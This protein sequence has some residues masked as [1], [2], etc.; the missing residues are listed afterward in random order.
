ML[1]KVPVVGNVTMDSSDSAELAASTVG[2]SGLSPA[3][4]QSPVD[5]P[6]AESELTVTMDAVSAESGGAPLQRKPVDMSA[7]AVADASQNDATLQDSSVTRAKSRDVMDFEHL[8]MKLDQLRGPAVKKDV[9]P[10][11]TTSTAVPKAK[12]DVESE[13]KDASDG[14]APASSVVGS[15][16]TGAAPPT[17]GNRPAANQ[18]ISRLTSTEGSQPGV[19]ASQQL[20]GASAVDTVSPSAPPVTVAVPQAVTAANNVP[21]SKPSPVSAVLPSAT[22]AQIPTAAVAPVAQKPV[23]NM[24]T[25]EQNLAAVLK[26]A[27][28]VG[29]VSVAQPVAQS[30]PSAVSTGLAPPVQTQPQAVT[31]VG[32]VQQRVA[33]PVVMPTHHPTAQPSGM[34]PQSVGQTVPVP[35]QLGVQAQIL[36]QQGQ[37][38]LPNQSVLGQFAPAV[39]HTPGLLPNAGSSATSVMMDGSAAVASTPNSP[40]SC[41]PPSVPS[42]APGDLSAI[43]AMYQQQQLQQQLFYQQLQQAL[44]ARAAAPWSLFGTVLPGGNPLLAAQLA[45]AVQMLM[46]MTPASADSLPGQVSQADLLMYA[47]QLQAQSVLANPFACPESVVQADQAVMGSVVQPAG[48]VTYSGTLSAPPTVRM[49]A[50]GSVLEH[51]GASQLSQRRRAERPDLASL[52][53]ALTKFLGPCKPT[54]QISVAGGQLHSPA[55]HI[56]AANGGHAT[57]SPLSH[58]HIHQHPLGTSNTPAVSSPVLSPVVS[59]DQHLAQTFGV[60]VPEQSLPSSSVGVSAKPELMSTA[61][62]VAAVAVNT[63]LPLTSELEKPDEK[64]VSVNCTNK[65]LPG[66]DKETS[67]SATKRKLQFTVTAVKNDPL[68]ERPDSK[69]ATEVSVTSVTDEKVSVRA[70]SES[71]DAGASSTA[72]AADVASASGSDANSASKAPIKKGRF[73]ILDVKEKVTDVKEN[74]AAPTAAPPTAKSEITSYADAAKSGTCTS[75]AESSASN[76]ASNKPASV[77]AIH[78]SSSQSCVPPA[79]SATTS[80]ASVS[81]LIQP[82]IFFCIFSSSCWRVV[83]SLEHCICIF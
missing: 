58:Q 73:R 68:K 74:P 60:G 67:A 82:L 15:L 24:S 48:N 33:S 55:S 46:A 38:I 30:L 2:K 75:V 4:F 43:T 9:P 53:Q 42:A 37:Q 76:A 1:Q 19:A 77:V 80:T 69:E 16:V 3:V 51:P 54:P 18:Q 70:A 20:A 31:P 79:V 32:L 36:T 35:Q 12:P 5:T 41:Q 40:K 59:L 72:K 63:A 81:Q 8:K 34:V 11:A 29:Q 50:A 25:L 83:Q 21:L 47:Q 26:P 71:C 57:S 28:T 6:V 7:L 52:E 66:I 22:A 23:S 64:P 13:S 62:D 10:A 44:V 17:S 49:Q 14:S 61:V 39:V 45:Y 78:T 65:D 27:G 56:V